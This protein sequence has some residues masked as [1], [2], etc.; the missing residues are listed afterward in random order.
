MPHRIAAALARALALLSMFGSVG[1]AVAQTQ[2]ARVGILVTPVRGTDEEIAK[3]YEPFRRVLARQGWTEGKN[4]SFEYRMARGAPPQ[5]DEPATELV[6]LDV[7]VIYATSA[8]ATRAAYAAT[9]TIPII[10]V[11]L[12]NDPVAAGY[13][14]SYG[15]PGRNVTGVF[16]DAPEFSGKWLQLLKTIVPGLSRVAVLWDP[17]P[18][19]AHLNAI[20]VAAR[21]SGIQLQILEVREPDDLD[22]AFSAFRPKTQALVILPSPMTWTQSARLA[23]LTIEYRLPAVSMADLFA[24]AGGTLSYGPDDPSIDERG[25]ILVARVLAGTKPGEIPIERPA[26]FVFIL[27]MKTVKALALTIPDYILLS[28]D[29]VIR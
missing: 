15:R 26:K 14:E 18:G 13:A 10:S 29:R 19:R 7:D 20:Q 17:T 9:R 2:L 28:A 23:K 5:F 8:P 11:D 25:A 12:T 4:V 27:N 16:L 6:K 3:F 24:E 1:E 22:K 21:T